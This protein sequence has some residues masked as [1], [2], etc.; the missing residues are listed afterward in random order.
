[1][2]VSVVSDIIKQS[3]RKLGVLRSGKTP[4]NQEFSD[5]LDD[6]N[7]LLRGWS[8]QPG[9]QAVQYDRLFTWTAGVA[10]YTIGP[11]GADFTNPRPL[12][13]L[14]AT[15]KDSSS[16]V[17]YQATIIEKDQYDRTPLPLIQGIPS[18]L[19]CEYGLTNWTLKP[20]F[21]PWTTM[22]LALSTLEPLAEY[23]A[24]T[25]PIGLPIEYHAALIF[26][27]ALEISDEV[28]RQPTRQTI[29]RA[30]EELTNIRNLHAVPPPMVSVAPMLRGGTKR[31]S[32][33]WGIYSGWQD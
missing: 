10:S 7:V 12:R 23:T 5:Y 13:F 20:R 9:L 33:S 16:G 4:T 26:N 21:V 6:L 24:V 17:K 22:E 29:L 14:N 19:F 31:R 2:A 1:M 3:M 25:N 11:S 30:A 8:S 28:G 15:F 27:L 18:Q 32:N